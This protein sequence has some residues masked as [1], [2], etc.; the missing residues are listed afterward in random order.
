MG[1]F[2]TLQYWQLYFFLPRRLLL[3]GL[4][5]GLVVFFLPPLP[6]PPHLSLQNCLLE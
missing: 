3:R 5:K 2:F 4:F 6:S 1:I